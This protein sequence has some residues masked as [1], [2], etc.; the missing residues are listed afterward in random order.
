MKIDASPDA[1]D[2]MFLEMDADNDGRISFEEFLGSVLVSD[3]SV[4]HT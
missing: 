3:K 1:M 2:M 4:V